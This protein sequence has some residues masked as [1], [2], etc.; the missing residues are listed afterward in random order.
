MSDNRGANVDATASRVADKLKK[1]REA[2]AE[3]P[4]GDRRD[5][6]R[7]TLDEELGAADNYSGATLTLVRNGG[8]ST[9]DLFSATGNLSALT[10]SG[11]LVLSVVTIGTVTTNSAGTL[12]LTFNASATQA[13]VNETLQSIAYSNSSDNPPASAQINWDFND[14]NSGAQGTGGALSATGSTTVSRHIFALVSIN[15]FLPRTPESLPKPPIPYHNTMPLRSTP[16]QFVKNLHI[17]VIRPAAT[18]WCHGV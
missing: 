15:T 11:N 17:G 13:R 8:A 12:L 3:L 16:G 7:R 1:V 9:E 14:G 10:E 18:F 5:A 6:F 4:E 2:S